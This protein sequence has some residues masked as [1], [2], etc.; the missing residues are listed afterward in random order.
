[1]PK[2]L[3][4]IDDLFIPTTPGL[5]NKTPD[6]ITERAWEDLESRAN[7][8]IIHHREKF[9]SHAYRITNIWIYFLIILTFFQFMG[10]IFAVG[11]D[12]KEFITV[13]TTTTA[14]VFGFGILVGKFLF[15]SNGKA[16]KKTKDFENFK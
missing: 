10:R 6:S 8:Q 2:P 12:Y 1:M 5:E 4:P 9:A 16:L 14:A 15:P 3:K 13:F 11:L 7:N